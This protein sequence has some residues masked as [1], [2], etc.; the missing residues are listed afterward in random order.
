MFGCSSSGIGAPERWGRGQLRCR[1]PVTRAGAP[2]P[3]PHGRAVQITAPLSRARA[4]RM[5]HLSSRARRPRPSRDLVARPLGGFDG[6]ARMF[7]ARTLS[8]FVRGRPPSASFLSLPFSKF[9]PLSLSLSGKPGAH[10][11]EESR[12]PILISS[13]AG[14]AEVLLWRRRGKRVSRSGTR[15]NESGGEKEEKSIICISR[16]GGGVMMILPRSLPRPLAR[17]PARLSRRGPSPGVRRSPA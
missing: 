12:N 5:G 17:A 6:L 7:V 9:P 11:R 14:A 13:Q 4:A 3:T 1:R 15:K 10:F 8:D 16:V 2:H